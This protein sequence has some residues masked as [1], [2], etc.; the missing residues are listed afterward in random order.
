LSS[1]LVVE[2]GPEVTTAPL[3][4]H[5]KGIVVDIFLRIGVVVGAKAAAAVS[6][7]VQVLAQELLLELFSD[8]DRFAS[9]SVLY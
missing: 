5:A 9:V 8:T 6:A 3:V 1:A 7:L 4:L 2:V